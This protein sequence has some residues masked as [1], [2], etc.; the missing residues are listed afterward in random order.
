MIVNEIETNRNLEDMGQT[1]DAV[2][3]RTSDICNVKLSITLVKIKCLK[4]QR[5]CLEMCSSQFPT[6]CYN[7]FSDILARR[8]Q[9]LV[10]KGIYYN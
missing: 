9:M 4:N 7:L 1:D 10:E 8:L 5:I 6:A 3:L 2:G